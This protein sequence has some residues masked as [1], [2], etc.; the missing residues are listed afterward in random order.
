MKLAIL[1][2]YLLFTLIFSVNAIAHNVVGGV[3]AIGDEIEGEVGFSNGSMAK[4][5]TIVTVLTQT[6]APIGEVTTDDNGFFTFTA[7]NRIVHVFTVNLGAGHQLSMQLAADELPEALSHDVIKPTSEEH[8]REVSLTDIP[9]I[10]DPSIL[11]LIDKA[12][13]KQIKPLRKEIQLL[14][15]KSGLRDI[16]GGIGYIFGLLGLI[17]FLRERKL[18]AGS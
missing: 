7:K 4:A 13:A 1:S 17:A 12:V 5:G 10:A 6:G 8:F 2:L 15:E 3:Y 14:R 16:I 11:L 9:V 18:K